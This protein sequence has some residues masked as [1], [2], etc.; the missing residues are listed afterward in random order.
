MRKFVFMCML[1]LAGIII[2]CNSD[3]QSQTGE[4]PFANYKYHLPFEILKIMSDSPVKYDISIDTSSNFNYLVLNRE[5]F[6]MFSISPLYN[7]KKNSDGSIEL[8]ED[9]PT[10]AISRLLDT[11]EQK[12]TA[13]EYYKAMEYYE[14]II[15]L[16]SG[17]FKGWSYL[18][19][20][21]YFLGEYDKAEFYFLKAISLNEIGYQEYFYLSDNNY[22]RGD[23]KKSLDYIIKG[24]MLNRSSK[25]IKSAIDRILPKLKLQYRENRLS[26]PIK[27]EKIS[28]KECNI[29]CWKKG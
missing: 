16:D 25:S 24:F 23:F 5:N 29:I 12:F 7:L 1:S 15:K 13:K 17:W 20:A 2:L 3:L 8:I 11:A 18:G 26:F 6:K 27:I 9:T 22:K 19:D 10:D 14:K 4:E 28:D 21:Y